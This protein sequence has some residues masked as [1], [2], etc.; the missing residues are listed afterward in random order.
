M[1]L[2]SYH[3]NFK[4]LHCIPS[5]NNPHTILKVVSELIE[6]SPNDILIVDDASDE[7][8]E[9]LLKHLLPHPRIHIIRHTENKGK[10]MALRSAIN[11]ALSRDYTHL[12]SSDADD[13]HPASEVL[14]IFQKSLSHPMALIIG[15]RNMQ[16]DN[17]PGISHFGRKFSNFWVKYQTNLPIADSQ[18]GLRCYPLF[19][20]QNES[21]LT[22]RFDFEIEVLI[23]L[24]WKEIQ[25]IEEN[26]AVVYHKGNERVSHF[27][28]F[29]DN[30]RITLLNTAL[31]ILSLI[32]E[33]STPA[34][35][36]LAIAL[37]VFIGCTPFYGLHTFMCA[38][39]S[40]F[41]RLN[42]VGLLAGSQISLPIFAPLLV[43]AA[44]H[45]GDKTLITNPFLSF[46]AGTTVL[47]AGLAS[48]TYLLSYYFLKKRQTRLDQSNN[49]EWKVQ[50]RGSKWGNYFLKLVMLYLSPKVCYFVIAL[51]VVPYFYVF[52]SK[53]R[54]GSSQ[55]WKT[56]YANESFF[57]R[58][59]RIIKHMYIYACTLVDSVY[60]S[61]YG[62]KAVKM[63]SS[64][65]EELIKTLEKQKGL[66]LL[67]GHF[68]AF[69][70]ASRALG[71]HQLPYD[72]YIV[73]YEGQGFTFSDLQEKALAPKEILINSNALP[74]LEIRTALNSGA[75]VSM[76]ADRPVSSRI[77]LF[78]FLGKWIV[79]DLS[80]YRTAI[81]CGSPIFYGFGFKEF[82]NSYVFT[83]GHILC[84]NT[85]TNK[86]ARAR[87]LAQNY[88]RTLE[89]YIK[90][91]PYQWFN[92]FEYFSIESKLF[93]HKETSKA[94]SGI[95][96]NKPNKK[97]ADTASASL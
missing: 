83:V 67:T 15:N 80:P 27:N 52:N 37:G 7:P 51:F 45:I 34:R 82:N 92:W 48:F 84:D 95:E 23:R 60:T 17:V 73:R 72:I 13:Q 68:G 97:E 38:A 8:I 33:Q 86:D 79:L 90:L 40:F 14:K 30:L 89:E 39:V 3:V 78:K 44:K 70:L 63:R 10:G 18:S 35:L 41:S 62:E 69:Y 19:H 66:L 46:F 12:I 57:K 85:E 36:S 1:H 96:P 77:E 28:K 65:Y 93:S 5:Y 76:T 56:L 74:T 87:I 4:H 53:A 55:Y 43:I 21:F 64:G 9:K 2:G 29:W 42:F 59:L 22:K 26:V 6:T 91:Y 32:K 58:Q 94:H 71:R 20:L 49:A 31:I 11:W 24:I 88:L 47:G 81:A 75:V 25:V 16:T 50:Q 54:K 61:I